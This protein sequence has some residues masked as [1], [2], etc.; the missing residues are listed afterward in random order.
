MSCIISVVNNKGG[1]GKTTTVFN[2]SEALARS[3]NKVLMID[4]DPQGSLTT[5][6]GFDPLEMS[7]TIYDVLTNK[8]SIEESI[9]NTENNN[10][11]V[12]TSSIDLSAAEVEIISKIGREFILKNKL[13]KIK[14]FYDYIVIDNS[15]SLG[16]LTVNS[17]IASDYVIA[18]VDPTYLSLKGLEILKATISEVKTLNEKLELMGVLVTMFD[19]RTTHNNEVLELLLAKYPV[20]KSVIKRTIKFADACLSSKSIIDFAGP[21]F[22]GSVAYLDLAKEVMQLAEKN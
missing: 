19:G 16:I 10:L 14:G 17:M 18:P 3:G 9:Y 22:E 2:L 8:I 21:S 7:H 5:Y 11:N 12:I 20:F 6:L 15:P 13:E 4:L 1:V